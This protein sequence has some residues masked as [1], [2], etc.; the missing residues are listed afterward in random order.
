M[1][2]VHTMALLATQVVHIVA[3]VQS[4]QL[5]MTEHGP[6]VLELEKNPVKQ[7]MQ[8]VALQKPQLAVKFWQEMQ[9]EFERAKPG[10]QL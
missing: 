3:L 4:V 7:E 9:V 10:L 5:V 1:V 8:V 2:P 6:Q